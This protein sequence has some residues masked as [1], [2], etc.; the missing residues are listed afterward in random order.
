M[1]G[2]RRIFGWHYRRTLYLIT[3]SVPSCRHRILHVFDAII[4]IYIDQ[5]PLDEP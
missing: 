4:Y 1:T 3:K 5:Y 2:E